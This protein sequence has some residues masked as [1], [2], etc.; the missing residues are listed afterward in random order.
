MPTPSFFYPR[1]IATHCKSCYLDQD[2]SMT[3]R[4]V[5]VSR[6]LLVDGVLLIVLAFVHLLETPIISTWLSGE[7][8]AE[9]LAHVSPLFLY[10]HI[11]IGIL[12]IPVGV[13]TLYIAAGIR[14]GQPFARIIALINAVTVMF[15]PLITIF[16][17]GTTPFSE[18]PFVIAA[19]GITIIGISMFIPLLWLGSD[20]RP[21]HH[22]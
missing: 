16:I 8:T 6:L 5:V 19:A 12:L 3:F 18:L 15:L 20:N 4:H 9:T 14:I 22:L 13:S 1:L 21:H 10:N 7:L 11:V 17:A 2:T